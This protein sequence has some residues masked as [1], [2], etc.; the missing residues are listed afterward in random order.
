MGD[1]NKVVHLFLA[2]FL[3]FARWNVVPRKTASKVPL[4]DL[5]NVDSPF[6]WSSFKVLYTHEAY[7][8]VSSS[9][10]LGFRVGVHAS[11][12]TDCHEGPIVKIFREVVQVERSD[13]NEE[14]EED[15]EA[16]VKDSYAILWV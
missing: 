11:T 5:D 4:I 1:L 15:I 12:G 3:N 6:E 8:V 2:V 16:E 7:H 9:L 13:V 10:L 14:R